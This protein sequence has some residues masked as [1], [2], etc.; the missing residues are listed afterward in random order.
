MEEHLQTINEVAEQKILI[1]RGKVVSNRFREIFGYVSEAPE[2]LQEFRYSELTR[3][4]GMV[5]VNVATLFSISSNLS[6]SSK[7]TNA[8]IPPSQASRLSFLLRS[9]FLPFRLKRNKQSNDV[10]KEVKYT[11]PLLFFTVVIS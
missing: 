7:G 5:Y 9:F 2:D 4:V 1:N 8:S 11:D 10:R 6:F 3:S